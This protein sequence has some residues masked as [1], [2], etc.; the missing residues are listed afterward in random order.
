MK[1]TKLQLM[2]RYCKLLRPLN[3]RS[4]SEFELRSRRFREVRLT[5][6]SASICKKKYLLLEYNFLKV[7]YI[8]NKTKSQ[9]LS[10]KKERQGE[11][12][13]SGR[14]REKAGNPFNRLSSSQLYPTTSVTYLLFFEQSKSND[15]V[16]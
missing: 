9:K 3:D 7:L 12:F 4:A 11:S 5:N 15:Q 6:V 14:A 10:L 13:L 8:F 16:E 2:L 1:R